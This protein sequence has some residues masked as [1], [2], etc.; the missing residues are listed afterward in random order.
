MDTEEMAVVVQLNDTTQPDKIYGE[1]QYSIYN[2]LK[3][4]TAF[5]V[6]CV[7]AFVAVIS[8]AL[9]YA[10]SQYT[11]A[12]LQYWMVDTVYAKEN[13]TELIYVILFTLLYASSLTPRAS[14]RSSVK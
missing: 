5:L 8:F 3:E 1:S 6:A 9:N 10:A 13:K 12:Y 11:G 7:S 14:A 2:Y 4:H